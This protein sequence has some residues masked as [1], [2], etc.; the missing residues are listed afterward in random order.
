MMKRIILIL[1]PTFLL[2][3]SCG[4]LTGNST[5]ANDLLSEDLIGGIGAISIGSNRYLF[6][7]SANNGG[8]VG[9]NYKLVFNLLEGQ[10][11]EFF[12]H[13]DRSLQGAGAFK[14]SRN[15]GKVT[16]QISVNGKSD[17]KVL[18]QFENINPIDIEI[19]FHNDHTDV[20]ILVWKLSGPHN[21]AEGCSF[22]STCI[23]N[24]EDF[25]L[26]VW[27]GVGKA[28]G[29]FW[30]MNGNRDSVISA[31]GPNPVRSNL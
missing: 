12:L 8:N 15:D 28:G 25:A 26:D 18:T 21:D 11:M 10:S 5:G 14:F 30:G 27:L 6:Q 4:K 2:L 9:N 22:D 19:D 20:H 13:G 17:Q 7:G 23:Y 29:P 3:A 24:T 31:V 16:L 1:I